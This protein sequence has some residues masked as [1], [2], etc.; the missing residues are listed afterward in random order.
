MIIGEKLW[1]QFSSCFSE[2]TSLL[3]FCNIF[4]YFEFLRALFHPYF[5]VHMK[6]LPLHSNLAKLRHI[7]TYLCRSLQ[8]CELQSSFTSVNIFKIFAFLF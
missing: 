6:T 3:L 4:H 7:N 2:V 1:W 8:V 5:K